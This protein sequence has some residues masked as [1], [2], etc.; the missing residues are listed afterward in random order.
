MRQSGQEQDEAANDGLFSTYVS[1]IMLTFGI[2]K[3]VEDKMKKANEAAA[4][5]AA[6]QKDDKKRQSKKKGKDAAKAIPFGK[7]TRILFNYLNCLLQ[8]CQEDS[9]LFR[10]KLD[11]FQNKE[12]QTIVREIAET[13]NET[14]RKPKCAKGTRDMSPRKMAIREKAF[15]I[16]RGIFKKHG[17]SEIDTPV[18]ELKETLT[19]K[20]GEESKLIYDL[21]DQGGELLSLRYDLTVPFARYVALRGL[22][23]IKRF[24]IAKVYR[25]D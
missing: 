10:K 11:F 13:V 14:S 23:S 3:E 24:H 2:N 19:S 8:E 12:L 7:G 4:S 18:F 15:G 1:E 17:A 22:S 20:Y 25:R 6:P 16:I 9:A 21:E 5:D